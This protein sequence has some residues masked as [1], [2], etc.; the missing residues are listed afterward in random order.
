M[1]N[2]QRG[3]LLGKGSFGS[4]FLVTERS[5][6]KQYVLKEISLARMPPQEQNAAKQEAEVC[7]PAVA[8]M[9]Y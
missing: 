8:R 2:Y 6:G 4:A 3:R 9:L 7:R 5:S 1:N